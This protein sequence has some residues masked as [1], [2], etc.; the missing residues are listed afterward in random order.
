[1]ENHQDS[2]AATPE[3]GHYLK[4]HAESRKLWLGLFHGAREIARLPG[5]YLTTRNFLPG[6]PAFP[7]T[8][9]SG[10]KLKA[11][12][13]A[14]GKATRLFATVH[15]YMESINLNN[16]QHQILTDVPRLV[17]ISCHTDGIEPLLL[18]VFFNPA[19]DCNDVSPWLHAA[20]NV[21]D[22]TLY[23]TVIGRM[24]MDRLP[25]VAFFTITMSASPPLALRCLSVATSTA[26]LNASRPVCISALRTL[27]APASRPALRYQSASPRL[28]QPPRYPGHQ[29]LALRAF[30]TTSIRQFQDAKTPHPP[31]WRAPLEESLNHRPVLVVGA[32]NIGR[33]VALVWASNE[34][35]VTIYDI[36]PEALKSA[37]TY[38]TDHLGE[39]CA[40]RGTHPG[41]VSTTSDLHIATGTSGQNPSRD[42]SGTITPE[43]H[44]KAPWLAI[45]CLPEI[46]PL[47]TSVL[48]MLERSLPADCILASNSSSLTTAEM[49]AEGPLDHPHRLLNTHYFI[50]P[51]N[52]MVE[53]MSSGATAAA[54]FP[55]LASQ[56]HRVG[57]VPVTVPRDIQSR[58]FVFNRIWAACKRET[59]AVLSEGV[60]KP[61]DIDALFCDFFHAEKGPCER[62]DEVGLD[63]V[64]RVEQHNLE[65]QPNLGSE[66]I[67][68]WLHDNY[69]QAWKLGDKSGDGLY[70]CEEREALRER[71]HL[72]HFKNVEETAVR[73]GAQR[74]FAHITI[75]ASSWDV[76]DEVN[77]DAPPKK[78]PDPPVRASGFAEFRALKQQEREERYRKAKAK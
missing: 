24:M 58:G 43:E 26:L 49:A 19:L 52:R 47:K 13:L 4:V 8:L 3:N 33:R 56:M 77:P 60:A 42:S 28:Q 12:G 57:L 21:L 15:T 40:S 31:K 17:T 46:L 59:L 7:N 45:E 44:T 30:S 36:S 9:G 67:L 76:W 35:P 78:R 68:Q 1:M 62:M 74:W 41:H 25:K 38:I 50:P 55:F 51:R 16:W 11:E 63:T 75:F 48:A 29:P 53:L 69:I 22:A 73:L 71:H 14:D 61:A 5:E 54:I 66:K 27:A 32:G 10:L 72:H 20:L 65:R 39:Y 37:T 64:H 18:S 2:G 70:T 6:Y 23:K 34:R